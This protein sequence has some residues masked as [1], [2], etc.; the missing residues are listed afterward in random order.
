MKEEITWKP[1]QESVKGIVRGLGK[2]AAQNTKQKAIS[3]LTNLMYAK[4]D[5]L[6]R[7]IS[8]LSPKD[9][10]DMVDAF[11]ALERIMDAVVKSTLN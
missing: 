6:A 9:K 7:E 2:L 1:K 10:R 3:R 8:K 4:E 11:A 5:R